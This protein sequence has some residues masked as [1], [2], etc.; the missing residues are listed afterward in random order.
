M[1]I[2]LI[3]TTLAAVLAIGLIGINNNNSNNI[4]N[5]LAQENI[6]SIAAGSSNPVQ[7][8]SM[9][10]LKLLYLQ[11]LRLHGRMMILLFIQ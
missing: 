11:E 1:K 8:N 2:V 6:V 5:A 4:P 3:T 10:L 7:Q 9:F